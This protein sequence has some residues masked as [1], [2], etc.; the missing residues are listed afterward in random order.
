MQCAHTLKSSMNYFGIRRG[1]DLAFGLEKMGRKADLQGAEE[2]MANL[3]REI[4]QAT[5]VLMDYEHSAAQEAGRQT[6]KES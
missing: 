3:Q 2:A 5:S 4:A 1:F 6:T